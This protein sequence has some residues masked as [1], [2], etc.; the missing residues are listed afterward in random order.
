M[1]ALVR[2]PP[3]DAAGRCYGRTD[4]P[5]ADPESAATLSAQL[6]G[7]GGI[8]WTSPLQRC[9]AVAEALGP[10]RPD[11]R[12]M[13]LDFGAWEGLP[14]DDVPREALDAWAADPWAFCPPGGETGA[15][16]VARIRAFWSDLPMGDHILI[17]HGGPLKVLAALA[18]NQP[19]DLLAPAPAPGSVTRR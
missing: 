15:A 1:I 12:L 4:L 18:T 11:D 3:V 19:I 5:L 8:I 17:S 14:W 16:L 9:R 6:A 7:Q 2:H 13:E 10:C